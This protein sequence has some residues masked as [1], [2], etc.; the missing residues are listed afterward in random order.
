MWPFSLYRRIRALE[1]RLAVFRMENTNQC[2]TI[3]FLID[4]AE[5]YS[6][7]LHR[8]TQLAKTQGIIIQAQ[9]GLIGDL[10]S[11]FGSIANHGTQVPNGTVQRMSRAANQA[12]ERIDREMGAKPKSSPAE[13][14]VKA[15]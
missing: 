15:A 8:Q 4:E 7:A 13:E 11:V 10:R 12:L 2:D 3:R 5:V 1:H 14:M 9:E 6:A